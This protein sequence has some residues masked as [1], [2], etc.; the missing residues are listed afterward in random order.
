MSLETLFWISTLINMPF[1]FL[2]IWLPNWS[3]T[4]RIVGTPLI[5]LPIALLYAITTIPI[6]DTLIEAFLNP[7]LALL[8]ESL[9]RPQNTLAT[10]Q[11]LLAFDFVAGY[12]MYHDGYGRGVNRWLMTVALICTLMLGPVGL[13]IYLIGRY[14]TA[15]EAS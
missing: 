9:S 11:H 8:S 14:T 7:S 6:F 1:W 2:M 13:I 10:W 15:N 4:K 5:L 3:W 12:W